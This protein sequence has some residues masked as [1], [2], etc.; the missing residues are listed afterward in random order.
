MER[1][2]SGAARA[3]GVV[4]LSL[5][6]LVAFYAVLCVAFGNQNTLSRAGPVLEPA[7]LER[8]LR[9]RR[10][11]RTSGTAG[12]FLTVS[13]RTFAF[14]A[15][16]VALSLADRLPGRL[17]HG[18]PRRPLEGAPAARADPAVLDQLPDADAGLDQPA[19][20]GRVGTKVLAQRW[21]SSSCSSR[22]G[23]SSSEGGWLDGQP[24]TVILALVYGYIPFLILPLFVALD[25]IDQRQI[26]A[27]RDLGA[28][29][30]ERV[31]PRDAAALDAGHP[32]RRRADRAADV[33]RLLHRRT[34]S[35]PRPR[36][37]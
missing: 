36:R 13:L 5:F 34:S 33:R 31:P 12:Q 29:P 25:R 8:R 2:G 26:E 10:A 3:P 27:A 24:I 18:P 16:A 14:V 1:A 6:F 32:R 35:R 21:R 23:C 11:A 20:A 4:W 30:G 7:R 9:P 15:I 19:R 22:S 37:T 28:Q 17:L